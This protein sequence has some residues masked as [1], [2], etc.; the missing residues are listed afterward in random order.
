MKRLRQLLLT[1]FFSL[2]GILTGWAQSTEVTMI[3]SAGKLVIKLYDD[4]PLHRD[5]F[6]KLVK[7]HYYDSL[8]FHRVIRDFMIQGGDPVSK[9]AG[10]SVA[11]G[12]GGPGYTIPAEIMPAKHFHKKGALAGARLGDEV[13]PSKASSG[14]Q[15][16]IVAGRKFS[17]AELGTMEQRM[18]N[19]QK[20]GIFNQLINRPENKPL[21]DKLVAFQQQQQTDSLMV[22]QKKFEGMIQNE[23]PK[24][25]PMKFSDEA[26][27]IYTT[28]GGTPH[29]DGNYTVFGEVV[30]GLDIVDAISQVKTAPGDRPE[31]DVRIISVS[32]VNHS[33]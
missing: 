3:T 33:K 28:M 12:N 9:N 5:N 21:K 26:K 17:E 14:S 24:V 18:L 20:Q 6:L 31:K 13:N 15:F 8:L 25:T 10:P 32:I 4:T 2:T 29:L 23:L 11:L 19:Q 22:L 1:C 27:G 16:Y 30:E 7:Q